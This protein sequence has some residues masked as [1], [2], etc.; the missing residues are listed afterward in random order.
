[1]PINITTVGGTGTHSFAKTN[2]NVAENYIY[3]KN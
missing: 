1:M 2:V 3:Y